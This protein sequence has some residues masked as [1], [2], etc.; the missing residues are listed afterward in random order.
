MTPF[1]IPVIFQEAMVPKGVKLAGLAALAHAYRLEFPVRSLSCIADTFVKGNSRRDGVW[2][3]YDKR[4][5]PNDSLW[6]HLLFALRHESIDLLGLKKIFSAVSQDEVA[7]IMRRSPG[8]AY[9]RRLWFFY[10]W[11]TGTLLDLPDATTGNYVDALEP[12]DYVTS[13]PDLS[14]R[15]R[16]R[17]NLLGVPAFCP[18]VRRTPELEELVQMR[19]D[20]QA[21]SLVGRL[22]RHVIARAA[23]FLLLSDSQASYQIEGERPPRN[24]IERWGRA[25]AQAGKTP[26]SVDELVRLQH[27][28]I[29]DNR[30]VQPG[31]RTEGGFIGERDRDNNPLPEFVSARHDDLPGLLG[32]M[33]DADRRMTASGIDAVVHAAALSFGFVFAHPFEDGNGRLHRYLIHHVLAERGFSPPGVFFPVSSVLLDQIEDY[34][35]ALGR[36]SGPL[37]PYIQWRPTEKL[38]VEILND[39]GDLYRYFDATELSVF[40]YRCVR[41]TVEHDLPDEIGY[42]NNSDE[43]KRRIQDLVEMPDKLVGQ[44]ITFITQNNGKLSQKRRSNEFAKLTDEEVSEIESAVVEAFTPPTDEDEPEPGV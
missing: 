39:T 5:A 21:Q 4:Y 35:E 8:S 20:V 18:V 38:N 12:S 19:L 23:S 28:I 41:R 11:L 10:E 6:G 29:E 36:H 15:H 25:V 2:T 1:E 40:L 33:I 3:I 16:V 34:R 37:M 31:L 27:I 42:L 13:I 30:F 26:L 14:P 32:G 17:D 44:L 24:R 7:E 22:S 43:A 9:A